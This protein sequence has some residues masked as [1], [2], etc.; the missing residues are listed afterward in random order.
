MRTLDR[1]R[2]REKNTVTTLHTERTKVFISYSHQDVKWLDRLQVHLIPLEQEK[3]IERWDDTNIKPGSKWR[4]DIQEAIATA[5]VAVLLISPNFLAS[6]FITENE[7][8]PLLK[9]AKEEGAVILPLIIRPSRF[10]KNPN[11]SQFQSVNSPNKPLSKLS[12]T[13]RDEVLVQLTEAIED[14][15]N[16]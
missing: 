12:I 3:K 14:A 13:K 7:L 6:K 11:L 1:S 9:A 15:L 16:P 2:G 8:P 4:E 5:K 10:M